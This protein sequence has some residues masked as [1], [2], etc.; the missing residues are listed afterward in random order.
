MLKENGP[1][2]SILIVSD[3]YENHKV[4]NGQR[5]NENTI[6]RLQSTRII[7]FS[8]SDGWHMRSHLVILLTEGRTAPAIEYQADDRSGFRDIANQWF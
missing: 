1:G 2:D 3:K 5:S 8:R 7:I 6:A 4:F